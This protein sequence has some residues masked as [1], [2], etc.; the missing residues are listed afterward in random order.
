M[1]LRNSLIQILIAI[2]LP[3]L[4]SGCAPVRPLPT[5]TPQPTLTH[6]PVPTDTAM[7]SPTPTPVATGWD[8]VALGDS[9]P[10]GFGV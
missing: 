1:R 2:V 8:Y 3:G 6:T 7:P 4:V 9:N 10:R 5:N